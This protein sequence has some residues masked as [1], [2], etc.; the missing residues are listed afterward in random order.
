MSCHSTFRSLR[1]VWLQA[2]NAAV[3]SRHFRAISDVLGHNDMCNSPPSA[4]QIMGRDHRF[5]I[6]Y[7]NQFTWKNI[8]LMILFL[9]LLF[10]GLVGKDKTER[11]TDRKTHTAII[12]VWIWMEAWVVMII[13][14]HRQINAYWPQR[15]HQ[16]SRTLSKSIYHTLKQWIYLTTIYT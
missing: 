10:L 15:Y 16:C 14:H 2:R 4:R 12:T 7:L 11:V 8:L 9:L 6:G 1:I 5:L 3:K 13:A